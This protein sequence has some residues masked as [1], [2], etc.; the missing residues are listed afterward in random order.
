MFEAV[1]FPSQLR[2][3][4]GVI[5]RI[6]MSVFD[7][8]GAVLADLKLLHWAD[9]AAPTLRDRVEFAG[10]PSVSRIYGRDG[11]T[12][13]AEMYGMAWPQLDRAAAEELLVLGLLLRCPWGFEADRYEVGPPTTV[14][15]SGAHK[16][17]I[18]VSRRPDRSAQVLG[19]PA[20]PVDRF[21][22]ICKPG[23][24]VPE[25]V[26]LTLVGGSGTVAVHLEDYFALGG[27]SI[28][29]RRLFVGPGGR[30]VMELR[31][32]AI[33]KGQTLPASMF[34]RRR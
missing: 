13:F 18:R 7:S 22:L 19:G 33:D 3:L 27:V 20:P 17:R 21:D 2:E 31:V 23:T 26:A 1:G 25:S 4:G 8:R 12:A 14:T 34:R 29:R 28:P 5:A 9:L 30:R 11:D 24:M 10:I 15:V 6:E 32:V 16:T